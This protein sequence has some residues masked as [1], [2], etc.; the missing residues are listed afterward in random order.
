MTYGFGTIGLIVLTPI[1][2]V[3]IMGLKMTINQK[4]LAKRY[5]EHDDE[6]ITVIEFD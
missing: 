2:I 3:E 6:E 1:L 4:R 5:A